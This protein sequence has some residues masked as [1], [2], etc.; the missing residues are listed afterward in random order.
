V[1]D[2]AKTI[3]K[4]YTENLSKSLL[5][6]LNPRNLTIFLIFLTPFS[7]GN[8]GFNYIYVTWVVVILFV[9][10]SFNDIASHRR[11]LKSNFFIPGLLLV[12][13]FFASVQFGL[14]YKELYEFTVYKSSKSSVI[15][16]IFTFLPM[17]ILV[18]YS[19]F[20]TTKTVEDLM[21]FIKCI[22]ISGILVNLISF[23]YLFSA[24]LIEGRLGGT[25]DDTNYFGRFEVLMV[26][27]SLS[28]I[29]FYKM[30]IKAKLFFIAFLIVCANFLRL[31]SSRAAIIALGIM[32]LASSVFIKSRKVKYS[33]IIISIITVV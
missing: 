16:D 19:I 10:T 8:F 14:E 27:V 24:K 29:L 25:F 31:S 12:L 11:I 6:G 28:F 3:R 22:I 20:V 21:L 32:V 13:S 5:I 18:V 30:D 23:G 7:L 2:D 1:S 17:Q 33:L 4:S 9:L 15:L 26:A